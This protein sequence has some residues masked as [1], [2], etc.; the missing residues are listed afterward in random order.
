MFKHYII[1]R[2]NLRKA[3]WTTTKSN[4][5]VLTDEWMT[6][7]MELFENFCFPS[8]KAQTNLDFEWWVFFDT[9]T[10]E[11]FKK[12]IAELAA[13]FENFKPVYVDGM[14]AFVPSILEKLS[15][16]DSEY[17]ITSRIDNDDSIHEDFVNE[18]QKQFKQQTYQA[19]DFVDG[20]ALQIAPETRIGL[21]RQSFN[22]FISLIEKNEN[23]K[24]VW[25][26]GHTDWKRESRIKRITNNRI[27][28]QIVHL[29][30]KVNAFVAYGD[31]N[32][33]AALAPFH[34]EPKTVNSILA[35]IIPVKNWKKFARK[36]YILS[37]LDYYFRDLKRQLGYYKFKKH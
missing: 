7:R 9:T 3:D 32:A 33:K 21:K 27:W 1:T 34:I 25:E 11:K 16:V 36:M 14:D 22:P 6:N 8:V 18:V 20:Y 23:P 35:G 17:L 28:L 30:N 5:A 13:S 31:V 4:S 29:E 24:T 10:D 19:L 12:R 2:F 15:T 26:K 37:M